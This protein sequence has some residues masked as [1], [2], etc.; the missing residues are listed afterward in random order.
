V[1]ETDG[2]ARRDGRTTDTRQRIQQVAVELFVQQ[3]FTNT[4]L[5]HIAERLGLTKA[6]LYYHFPS[7]AE[8]VASVLRPAID[9]VNAFLDEA[10]REELPPR[11]VL[12]R[13]FDLN[14]EHHAVF[15][16]LIRDPAGLAAVDAVGWV[17]RLATGFQGLL[18]G[19]DA[20]P[21]Q[22]IR[23]IIAA[24][25]LSRCATL[26]TDVPHDELRAT[27]VDVAVEIVRG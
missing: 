14:Y 18:A 25:G 22:R 6:A 27:T 1:G 7:K 12:E 4:S 9:G 19:R 3:G 26:L 2:V 5:Q 23:A 13:F 20:S 11:E 24:N 10:E 16:A 8:L 17:N 21:E 15:A